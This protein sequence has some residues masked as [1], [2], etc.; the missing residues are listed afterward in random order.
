MLEEEILGVWLSPNRGNGGTKE[1]E[2]RQSSKWSRTGGRTN[3][4]DMKKEVLPQVCVRERGRDKGRDGGFLSHL[5]VLGPSTYH[6]HSGT[7]RLTNGKQV[8]VHEKCSTWR[9]Q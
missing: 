6:Q 4:D 8:K 7:S 3:R 5:R 1:N 9:K 2:K